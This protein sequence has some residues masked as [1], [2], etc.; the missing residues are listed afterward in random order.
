LA[1]SAIGLG[2]LTSAVCAWLAFMP[3]RSY[4]SWIRAS[5]AYDAKIAGGTDTS[6][7]RFVTAV[8]QELKSGGG[9]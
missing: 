8:Y 9:R 7:V 6:A 1:Q 2:G 5:G 3:P 4:R